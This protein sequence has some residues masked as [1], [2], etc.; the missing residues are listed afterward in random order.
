MTCMTLNTDHYEDMNKK[1]FNVLA[2]RIKMYYIVIVMQTKT[3]NIYWFHEWPSP[4]VLWDLEKSKSYKH[5]R[6]LIY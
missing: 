4:L 3:F 1:I 6:L 2:K 5:I